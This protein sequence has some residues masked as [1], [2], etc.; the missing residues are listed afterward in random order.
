MNLANIVGQEEVLARL[1]SF[2]DLYSPGGGVIEHILLLGDEGMGKR[3]IADA[4]AGE[5][6]L[7]LHQSEDFEKRALRRNLNNSSINGGFRRGDFSVR[8]GG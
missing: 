6:S 4:F 7:L 1:K 3:T 5:Y 8:S 2:G